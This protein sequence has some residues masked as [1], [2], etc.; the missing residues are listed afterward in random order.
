MPALN[1]T[2]RVMTTLLAAMACGTAAQATEGALGRPVTGTSVTPNAGIVPP[3]P[4]FA[5]NLGQIYLDGDLKG[6]R[7]AP[8]AGNVSAGI[9]GKVSFTLATFMKVWDTHTGPWNFASSIT[10]PY[11]YTKVKASFAAGPLAGSQEDSASGLFDLYFTPLIA[12]FHI[13]KTEHIALS[14][15]IWAPTGKY[16]ASQLANTSLNNWTYIPQVAYTAILPQQSLQF[17]VTAGMQFYTKNEDTDYKNA[18]LFTLDAM[19][20]RRFRDGLS[21]GLIVGTTQQIG[22]DSG[23]TADRLGGFRGWDV[24]LGPI[25]TYDAKVSGGTPLSLSLRWVPTI[26]SHNRL[27]STATVM[28]TA[29]LVF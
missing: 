28:G 1:R 25:V 29:T 11:V 9:D 13:S 18:P 14:V 5:V 4:I 17:D 7:P 3:S 23:P 24:A 2:C 16:D 12:G 8:I 20:L 21:A 22:H 15:N 10:L 26:S 27:D 6:S 19:V